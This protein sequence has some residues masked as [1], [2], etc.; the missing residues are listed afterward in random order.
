MNQLRIADYEVP[1]PRVVGVRDRLRDQIVGDA[2]ADADEILAR[3]PVLPGWLCVLIVLGSSIAL[4]ALAIW[5]A[6]AL[7]GA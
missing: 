3:L 2:P 5:G 6:L 7:L 4:W 1:K